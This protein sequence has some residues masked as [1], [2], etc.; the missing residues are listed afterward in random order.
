MSFDAQRFYE[1]LPVV[2][3]L[4]D[5]DQGAPLKALLS[6]MAEQAAVLEEDL[7]QLYDD[8]FIET[9][10]DWVV[11]YIGDLIGC[12]PLHG[13]VPGISL[14][15]AEVANT[16]GYRRRKGTAVML[17]QLARDVTRWDARVVEFFQLLS[18]TQFMNHIRPGC[19]F[20]PNL[21][22]WQKTE[23]LDTAFDT[24]AHTVDVR[25]ISQDRGRYNIPNVGIFIW[26]LGAYSRTGSSAFALD[27]RRWRFSPL[28]NDLPLFTL[29]QT[30]AELTQA[31]T[32]LNVPMPISRRVLFEQLSA[33]YGSG[34]SILLQVDGANVDISQVSVCDLADDQGTW[35]NMNGDLIAIDPELGRIA[36][37]ANHAAQAQVSVFYQYGFSGPIGGGEYEREGSFAE[38][39]APVIEVSAPATVQSAIS[40]SAGKNAVEISDSGRY[41]EALTI[42][43][44][45]N[46]T[47][48]LRAADFQQP[49]IVL[50]REMILTGGDESE[51]VLNGL[52]IAGGSLRVPATANKL[53]R[54]KLIHCTLVPGLSLSG[55]G[56]PQSAG[57]PSLVIDLPGIEV[58]IQSCILGGIGAVSTA[59][60]QIADSI[61]DATAPDK[62]AYGPNAAGTTSGGTLS[63]TNSTVIGCVRSVLLKLVSNSIFLAATSPRETVPPVY[64]ERKQAGCVRFSSLP[65]SAQTPRRFRCQPDLALATRAAELGLRSVDDLP[66]DETTFVTGRVSPVFTSTTYGTP[67]YCQLSLECDKEIREGADDESEMG[68]FHFLYQPQRAGNLRVR[69]EEYLRFGLEAGI[70]YA[71]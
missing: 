53:T 35:A 60:V 64:S 39:D 33:Y 37:P 70:I 55:G 47:F 21:R 8:Q 57:T 11:P 48:E 1:L 27:A 22:R 63:I 30:Q 10:A 61:V 9:C 67:A 14:P 25:R 2:Y 68:A 62:I 29:P 51:I 38:P 6:I 71:S 46:E 54:L 4:R 17:E 16:I 15:R 59:T 32:P 23:R 45:A 43:A 44:A 52:L 24:V 7:N 69:L 31:A 5:I 50:N 13:S 26:R 42:T 58:T 49:T 12:R 3:R 19:A 20:A 28:G 18:W 41:P 56:G 65:P 36:F 40:A 34:K 66:A